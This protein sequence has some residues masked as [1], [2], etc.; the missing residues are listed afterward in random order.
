M[1]NTQVGNYRI[2]SEIGRGSFAV[3]FKAHHTV[4]FPTFFVLY[5]FGWSRA[6]PCCFHQEPTGYFNGEEQLWLPFYNG[7]SLAILILFAKFL[8]ENKS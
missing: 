5:R 8:F 7:T 4:G 2:G 6:S 3:V 1:E